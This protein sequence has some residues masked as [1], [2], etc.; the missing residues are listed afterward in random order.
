ML[1]SRLDD[2][3]KA[4]CPIGNTS[5]YPET[6]LLNFLWG[7]EQFGLHADNIKFSTHK[8]V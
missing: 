8:D 3:N 4:F 7:A 1:A 5:I 6:G 2:K